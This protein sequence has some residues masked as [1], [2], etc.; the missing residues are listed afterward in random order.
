[1]IY[2]IADLHIGDQRVFDLCSRPFSSLEEFE[3][4]LIHRWNNKVANDDVVF[5]LGDI[6]NCSVEHVK[7]VFECLNGSKRLIIGNH[8]DKNVNEYL[9]QRIIVSADGAK[10]IDDGGRLVFLC[11]YPVMD[12]LYGDK[13]IYHVY[14]HVHNK[15][16]CLHRIIDD[17]YKDKTAY[18]ASADVVNFEP[19]TLD[20]LIKIKEEG[21]YETYIN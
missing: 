20:E 10:Y 12:W 16:D 14:G 19:V 7:K 5:I 8:D 11:H 2:Y 18:N 15:K 3:N 1:M 4:E 9:A 17:F 21:T 6:A 13:T